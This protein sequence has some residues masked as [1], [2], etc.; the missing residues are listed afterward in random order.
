MLRCKAVLPEGSYTRTL[1]GGVHGAYSEIRHSFPALGT[2]FVSVRVTSQ[3]E[4]EEKD[5][6][7]QVANLDR[8]RI[9]VE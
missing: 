1:K 5:L 6:F 3:R 9:V 8:A 2:Y 4:G 7:T